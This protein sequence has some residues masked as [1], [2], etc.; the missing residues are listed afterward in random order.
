MSKIGRNKPCPCGSGKKNKHC[1]GEGT[2]GALGFPATAEGYNQQ[3]NAFADQGRIADAIR[4]YEKAL[5]I[6]PAFAG[7][8]NNLGIVMKDQRNFDRAIFCY[9]QAL[10]FAPAFAGAHNNLGNVLKELG[11]YAEAIASYRQAQALVPDSVQINTNLGNIL[12][13]LDRHYEAIP[14]FRRAL[15]ITPD[16]SSLYKLAYSLRATGSNDE[17]ISCCQKALAVTPDNAALLIN[18][19][20]ACNS[21]GR[22]DEAIDTC[23]RALTIAPDYAST[24]SALLMT[25]QYSFLTNC[26]ESFILA[27]QFAEKF[28]TP[29]QKTWKACKAEGQP[30]GKLRI[31]LV[32]ADLRSHPVGYFLEAVLHQMDQSSFDLIAYANQSVDDDLSERI[33]PCFE[34]WINVANMSDEQLAVQIRK[35]RIDLLLDL[36]GH[37]NGSRLLTFARKPAPVQATWLGYAN[38]TGLEA[39]DFIIADPITIPPDDERFYS[40][41]VWRLPET[42]VCFTP[43]ALNLPVT[44]LPALTNGCITFGCFNYPAKLNDMV[45]A[46]WSDILLEVPDSVLLLKYKNFDHEAE[47]K[48]FRQ[49]FFS[50]G[51]DPDR[52]RFFGAS[53]REEYLAAYQKVDFC[54]D[55]F[56]FPGLTTTCEALWMGVPTLTLRMS[57]G[58]YGHNG[59]LVMKSIGLDDWVA[60]SVKE[61]KE[62]AVALS[63]DLERLAALRSGLRQTLLDS[64][65]CAAERFARNLEEA[66]RGMVRMADVHIHQ[67]E[68][69]R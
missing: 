4:C 10:F 37:S 31:G 12:S 51:V 9:Q 2:G 43:P 54:L 28:E 39:M 56:P 29:F 68:I 6:N 7:A 26:D 40:E 59:E 21:Q 13:D 62:R 25:Q 53:P 34:T 66:F 24:Y 1:C 23:Q 33:K 55:P 45:V 65:L 35:D 57:R 67:Q 20:S 48:L 42:Y 64:P 61:Y 22:V 27:R 49:R 38:S 11:Q 16:S 47:R 69:L 36:S 52:L 15:A 58:M 17:A 5:E 32:S 44:G 3:G 41:K 60:N 18:M 50:Y 19:A 63:F 14:F 30:D 46:C 8:W